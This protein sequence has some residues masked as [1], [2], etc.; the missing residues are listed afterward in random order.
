MSIGTS[1][2]T[3]SDSWSKF[4]LI[5]SSLDIPAWPFELAVVAQAG[6]HDLAEVASLPSM[7]MTRTSTLEMS[8][9]GSGRSAETAPRSEGDRLP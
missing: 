7:L 8:W 5:S 2:V 6:S 9:T 4:V 3:R 1:V